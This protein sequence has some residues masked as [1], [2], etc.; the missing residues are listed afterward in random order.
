SRRPERR[1]PTRQRGPARSVPASIPVERS[2]L[3]YAGSGTGNS[4]ASSA[5]P[6]WV[7]HGPALVDVY[8]ARE[9]LGA[10]D[11]R[12]EAVGGRDAG[13]DAPAVMDVRGR[14]RAGTAGRLPG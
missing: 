14:L 13:G 7:G 6:G 3:R 1:Y 5:L 10:G 2:L 12:R 8:T 11:A 9:R 4:G